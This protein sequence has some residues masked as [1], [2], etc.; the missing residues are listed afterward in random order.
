MR[1]LLTSLAVL[2]FTLPL[3]AATRLTATV[4]GQ[5]VP[6]E[7]A[8]SS[9]PI[10]YRVDQ[11]LINALPG[12][13]GMLDR[14]FATWESIPDSRA[15]F[16]QVA[17]ENR[18][19]AA[20]QDGQSVI[21][22]SDDLFA[23]QKAIALTTT[24]DVGGKLVESDI[25][26][27]ATMITSGY[28]IQHAITHEI[29]H[30]LGL[31][32]SASL[33]SIM[34]PYVARGNDAVVLDSD[35]TTAI[36]GIY[37]ETDGKLA[38]GVLQGRVMGDGGGIFAAQVVALNERGEPIATGL[39]DASG[40]FTLKAIPEGKYR[41]YAEPLDGPVEVK[42]LSPY[43]RQV[44]VTPFPTEFYQ[45]GT[46]DVQNG[47]VYG[48]LVVRSSGPVQVNPKWVGV[49]ASG[50]SDFKLVSTSALIKA[51]QTMALAVGGDGIVGGMTTFEV[52]SPSIK[53]V[54]DFRYSSNYVFAN[55]EIAADAPAG[56]AVIMVASGNQSAALTG[57]LRVQGTGGGRGRAVRR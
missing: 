1:T 22:I 6:V 24:W 31:D 34:Y 3:G 40:E 30:M 29:G 12:G 8:Q 47:R 4:A 41:I 38:G 44:K 28:N 50:S 32:H 55:Y 37:A 14:A 15:T 53:R 43:W 16:K 5:V 2:I 49:S 36:A 23:N 9:L 57:A 27:D 51:G 19:L 17:V 26:L 18:T 52:L 21:T 45:G 42:Q 33:S 7:W 54:S 10:G 11:R 48:N 39:T 46:I 20:G 13:A 25:Q 35:D 56:A